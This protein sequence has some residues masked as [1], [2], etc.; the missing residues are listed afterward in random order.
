MATI[1]DLIFLG[2]GN[3]GCIPNLACLTA[4]DQ[5][6]QACLSSVTEEGRKNKRGNVSVVI[7]FRKHS[8][9]PGHRLRTI[10]IDCGKTFYESSTTLFP[11]YGIR[12]LDAVVLT[13]G[14][15]DAIGGLDDLR[16]LTNHGVQPKV[17]LFLCPD[18]MEVVQRSYPFLVSAEFATGGGDVA[19]F[20]FHV[21]DPSKSILIHDLQLD[22]LPVHHGKILATGQ[23]F[24]SHGFQIGPITYISDT[25]YIPEEV[26]EHIAKYKPS[27]LVLDCLRHGESHASHYGLDDAITATRRINALKSYYVGFGHKMDHYELEKELK[28]LDI[29]V[30]P[31]FDGLRVDFGQHDGALIETSYFTESNIIS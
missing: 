10:L 7:R 2:T 22:P 31:A 24:I 29:R 19:T 12:E 16:M 13:H 8:D 9:P 4:P 23:P 14:H 11:K 18:T 21:F 27:I 28:E 5:N 26:F 25:N 17:D 20:Q 1:V 3:S 6:C 15:M 30:A